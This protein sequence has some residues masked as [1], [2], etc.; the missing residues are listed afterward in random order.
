MLGEVDFI[1]ASDTATFFDP[2]VT[3]GMPAVFEPTLMLSRMPITEL[4]RMTL[5]GNHER[6]SA[7]RAREIGLVSEVVPPEELAAAAAWAATAIARQPAAAV[8]A[9]LRTIWAAQE[10]TRQQAI[11]LGTTFLNLA[12]G[13]QA[14]SEGQAA[15][16]SGERVAPRIR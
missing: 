6:M 4:L 12:M 9:T 13:S 2:H 11:D 8:Q 7:E 16:A 14:L 10:L 15:F 1:I 3:Y 5:L